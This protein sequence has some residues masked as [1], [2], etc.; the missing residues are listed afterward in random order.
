MS[1]KILCIEDNPV[2]YRLVQRLLSQAGY[3][4]HWAEEGLKGFEMALEIKPELVLLDINLPGLSGFEV[5]TKFRQ[6]PE[7]KHTPIVALTAKTLKSDR[8]TALVAGC[9][10][11]IPKPI[12]PF[13]FVRQV[14]GYL[15][16]QRERIEKSREGAVLRSFNAQMLEHLEVQLKE[17][18]DA[19]RKLTEAQQELEKRNRSLS[20]LFNL[21]QTLLGE[22]DSTSLMLQVLTQ[23]RATANAKSLVAYRLHPSGGYWEGFRWQDGRFEPATILASTNAFA[24]RLRT[25]GEQGLIHGAQLRSHRIWEEGLTLGFWGPNAEMCLQVLKDRQS[26]QDIWGFWAFARDGAE[27]FQSLELELIALHAGLALVSIENAELIQNLHESTR[28]LASSYERME[29]AYADLQH[30]KAELSRQDRRVILEDLFYKITRRLMSPVQSLNHQSLELD[31]IVGAK[32]AGEAASCEKAS[33]VVSEVKG[34]VSKIDGLLKALMRRVDRDS[35]S[36]PEWLDLH[37]LLL[38]ELELLGAEG[39]IPPQAAVETDLSAR[40]P[41][42]FGVYGDFAKLLQN[43]ALHAFGGPMPSE[44]ILVRS[45]KEAELFHLELQDEGGPIPPTELEGAFEPFSELHQQA[46]IG[47]R[48][49]G[50]S[51]PLCK[52]LL[53]AYHGEIEI[54]NEGEGT[55]VHLCFPLH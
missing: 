50:P 14:E 37:D 55:A 30:A 17:A 6:Q 47:I 27:P 38:Q 19:N 9:D 46:V 8:D 20:Q 11:F 4:M 32:V 2:N 24:E 13:T 35:P 41:R 40:L 1:T 48:S 10:G 42:I 25:L 43:L 18:Q 15:G 23:V 16:G 36:T 33:K 31:Q 52:Q 26:E 53:A 29:V 28:A 21:S 12:D 5:A 34:A 49:P 54:R 3:E 39:V 22:H 7:L 45:W 44:K 51:L